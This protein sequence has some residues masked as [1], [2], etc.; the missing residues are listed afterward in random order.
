MYWVK[1]TLK[2][3]SYH[4]LLLLDTYELNDFFLNNDIGT[5][6]QLTTTSDT[7]IYRSSMTPLLYIINKLFNP[8]LENEFIFIKS[9]FFLS[10]SL[11]ILFYLCLKQKFKNEE[12]LLLIL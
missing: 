6:I 8:F 11:P 9:I 1:I 12:N 10:L 4:L 3:L 2:I 7:S 5:A